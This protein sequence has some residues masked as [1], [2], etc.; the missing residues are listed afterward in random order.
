MNLST[1]KRHNRTSSHGTKRTRQTKQERIRGWVMFIL[2]CIPICTVNRTLL[3]TAFSDENHMLN[4]GRSLIG[5]APDQQPTTGLPFLLPLLLLSHTL[6]MNHKARREE[7][8]AWRSSLEHFI[9]LFASG[10]DLIEHSL[11]GMF[12]ILISKDNPLRVSLT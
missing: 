6:W 12:G 8:L 9:F 11:W 7:R 3:H 4:G 10:S 5:L 1:P 2:H